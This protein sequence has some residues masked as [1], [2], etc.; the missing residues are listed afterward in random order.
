MFPAFVS[1][2]LMDNSS[3]GDAERDLTAR[4]IHPKKVILL[5]LFLFY[6]RRSGLACLGD[7]LIGFFEGNASPVEVHMSLE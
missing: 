4:S 2:R 5:L 3:I 6:G 7:F 1:H